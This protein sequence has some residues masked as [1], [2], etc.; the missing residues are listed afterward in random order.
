M[1]K[2]MKVCRNC[3]RFTDEKMCPNCKSNDLSPS[4][5]GMVII[6]NSENSEISKVLNTTEKGK[7]A[8]YVG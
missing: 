4:W 6:L 3:K 5:K 1:V 2:R 8:I 7:Y